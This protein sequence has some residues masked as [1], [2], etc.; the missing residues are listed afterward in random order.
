MSGTSPEKI[1]SLIRQLTGLRFD[2]V[3]NLNLLINY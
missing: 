1:K 2:R 3:D